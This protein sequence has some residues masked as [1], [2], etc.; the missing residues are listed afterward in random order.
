[1]HAG[2]PHSLAADPSPLA[3]Q[4]P[5]GKADP[6]P[7]RRPHCTVHAGRYGQ[8]AGGIH[9]T[10]MPFLLYIVDENATKWSFDVN[11]DGD[12]FL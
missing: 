6:P 2:I 3:R 7:A 9:P 10:G 5:S 4:T 11:G 12:T 1:M 8:Q